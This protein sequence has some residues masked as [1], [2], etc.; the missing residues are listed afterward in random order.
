MPAVQPPAKVLVSGATGYIAVWVVQNLLERGYTVRGAARSVAKGDFLKKLF[1]SHGDR[2]E[3]VVVED[4]AKVSLDEARDG[5]SR[6]GTYIE[7]VSA[8][9]GVTGVM[10]VF[11]YHFAVS[12][13][14]WG[15][16][17]GGQRHGCHRTHSV[18]FPFERSRP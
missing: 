11:A 15:I 7:T 10:V 4:I 5:R 3:V 12:R 8:G 9:V 2:F 16:R 6:H 13:L 14:G 1:A 18:A 17:R